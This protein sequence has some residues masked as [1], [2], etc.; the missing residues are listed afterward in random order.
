MQGFDQIL[1]RAANRYKLTG[2]DKVTS[3]ILREARDSH[4]R[5][6][7]AAR[8]RAENCTWR[9]VCSAPLCGVRWLNK[10]FPKRFSHEKTSETTQAE[11]SE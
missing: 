10:T 4:Y 1:V 3:K 9:V 8:R 5:K 11:P 6:M 7:H 2:V